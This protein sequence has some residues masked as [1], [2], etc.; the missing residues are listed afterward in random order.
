MRKVTFLVA[1]I[2]PM[3][4]ALAG[5]LA[6]CNLPTGYDARGGRT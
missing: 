3:S 5:E 2:A 6:I 1:V 4:M